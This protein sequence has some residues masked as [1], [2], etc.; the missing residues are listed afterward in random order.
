MK[1]IWQHKKWPHFEYDV[2]Q[3]QDLLYNYALTAG[4][5]EAEVLQLQPEAQ[6]DAIVDVMVSE[7]LKTSEIEGE[8]ISPDAVRSSIRNQLG[9][10]KKPEPVKDPRAIGISKLMI[11]VRKNYRQPLT[12]EELFLWHDMIFQDSYQR[13]ALEIGTWRTN[14]EPMQI[15][16]GAI[17]REIIH[18]EAPPSS[19]VN[20]EMKLFIAWFNET[21]PA[22]SKE[23]IAG[24]VRAAIAHLYFECI[25][26]FADGNGRIGRAISEK[27]L[28]Q[29]L[30]RPILFSMSTLIQ[31]NKKEYYQQLSDASS[32]DITITPWIEYFV[33][34]IYASVLDSKELV[35]G[36]IQKAHF[37][38][39]YATLLN[40]RQTKVLAR[41]F[42]EGPTGFKGDINAAKYMRIAHCAKA[43]ATRDL[44]EL[45]GFGCLVRLPGSGRSTSYQIRLT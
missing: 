28:T 9:L 1:Y 22:I 17:G 15:V 14:K 36:T 37:W 44:V 24:P 45:L 38:Q 29:E 33:K 41:M 25:H 26:P 10:S 13:T 42:E 12:K 7:A 4:L 18:Y 16:S 5:L 21:D 6:I 43:T 40:D 30:Q 2:S 35:A 27:A 39:K 8:K 3:I 23:P 32:G 34:T 19:R 11:E 31:K 20:K